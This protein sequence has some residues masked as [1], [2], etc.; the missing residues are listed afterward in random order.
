MLESLVITLR[1][2][3]EAALVVGIVLGYLRKTGRL[4]AA[5]TVYLGLVAG[6]V[7]SLVLGIVLH[8]LNITELGDAYEGGLMLVAAVF[9]ATMVWWMWHAGRHM[10]AEIEAKLSDLTASS[11]AAAT[12]GLFLF[13]FL[14][15]F[16][17]GVETVL[18]LAA[19]SLGTTSALLEFTGAVIGL[20][21]AAGFGVAFF[22]GSLRVNLSRFFHI[23]T[24]VLLAISVQLL[25]TGVHELSEA[26]V[27][28]SSTQEMRVV[29]PVVNNDLLFIVLVIAVCLFL[30]TAEKMDRAS[31]ANQ[32]GPADSAPLSAPQRRKALA[33]H[34][35]Q[36]F[37]KLAATGL[38]LSAI[39]LISAE[40]V[41]ARVSQAADASEQVAITNGELRIPV[42]RLKD[43]VL[44]HFAVSIDGRQVR[45]IAILDATDTVR[46]ALD[47]CAICGAQGYYQ[48]G[49]NV[50]CRNC[51]AAI[52]MPT[53][54][55]PGGC[56][57]IPFD[58][59][60]HVE[61]DTL[62]ISDTALGSVA[63]HFK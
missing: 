44:H 7:A 42:A 11:A 33:A 60:Y 51:G 55:H 43:H 32:D 37:W 49:Q 53:I 20:A 2:G 14:M 3:V 18:F 62:V 4:A 21:L 29:G 24:V 38:A 5:R 9:V 16:R 27:L 15:V 41:Y 54:G 34:R 12:F 57:P 61:G 23:T 13:V 35:R 47:A 52:Y 59:P 8:G 63:G 17:E 19:V 50:I 28:P 45:L 58:P 1:E 40:I 48:R 22:K 30:V 25:V 56:N 26:G 39:V 46:A 36:R 10:R 6:A 31:P